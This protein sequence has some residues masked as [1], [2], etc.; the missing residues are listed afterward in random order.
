MRA[1][2]GAISEPL[3]ASYPPLQIEDLVS[4][5][6]PAFEPPHGES[7]VRTQRRFDSQ[8]L[9][10][11]LLAGA[12][13]GQK[14]NVTMLAQNCAGAPGFFVVPDA[15]RQLHDWIAAKGGDQRFAKLMMFRPQIAE[16]TASI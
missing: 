7:H 8:K 10:R 2:T 16:I 6:A 15:L 11:T 14:R 5:S 1:R 13:A 9:A 12:V 3:S 4:G